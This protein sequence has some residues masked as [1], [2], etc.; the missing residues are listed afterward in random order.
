[1]EGLAYSQR[2]HEPL[3]PENELVVRA[4]AGDRD[5]FAE[6]VRSYQTRVYAVA[7]RMTRRHDVADDIAQ[8]TFVRAY[9][10]LD[11]FELGRP[12]GPWL[13]KIAV[14][15]SI[16]YLNAS[17]RREETCDAEAFPD[18]T[19]EPEPRE[20]DAFEQLRS[21]EFA[22]ALERAVASLPVEQ[23]C[24]FRLKVVEGMRYEEIATALNLS[25][26]TVMS[27]L[28]RARA[29]LKVLLKEHL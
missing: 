8:D 13:K 17:A 24:V 7:M 12:L 29:R 5:A 28:S 21:Q 25:A 18:G 19:F 14:N 10:H 11:R 15:L 27:R 3:G 26:G 9:R 20:P 1:M 2:R 23:Q 4:R 6:I 22:E 16:N